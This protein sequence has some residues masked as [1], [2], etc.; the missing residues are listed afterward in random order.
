VVVEED[1]TAAVAVDSTAVAEQRFTGAEVLAAEAALR[2][3]VDDP[4]PAIVAATMGGA[5]TTV[6]AAVT[7]GATA[8]AAGIG[9][10]DMVMDGAGELALGGRIGAGDGA[11]RMATI[12]AP[13]ITGLTLIMLTRATVLRTIPVAIRILTAGTTILR[14]QIRMH[15]RSPTRVDRREPGDRRYRE[16]H[17][18]RATQTAAMR[19]AGR[20]CPLTG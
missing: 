10:E 11:I 19:R 8:G 7:A 17:P 4:T 2:T 5:A 13:G 12:T 18:T 3:L 6:V 20:F 9:A 16:A 1:F 15:G 14:R